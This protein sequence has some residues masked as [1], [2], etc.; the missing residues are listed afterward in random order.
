MI[1][2]GCNPQ[3]P[4]FGFPELRDK[5]LYTKNVDQPHN[6]GD[7]G[8]VEVEEAEYVPDFEILAQEFRHAIQEFNKT[9]TVWTALA[10]DHQEDPGKKAY[11]LKANMY[12]EMGKDAQEKFAK[13]GGTWPRAGV[14]LAQ[15]IKSECPDQK[16]NWDASIAE[17]N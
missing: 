10:H 7:G 13:V 2:L 1:A 6:L 12:Q 15:R 16:I 3:G 5:N 8:K 11:V 9:E 17:K 4:K 14:S